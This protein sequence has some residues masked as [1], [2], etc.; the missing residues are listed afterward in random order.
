[1]GKTS[2]EWVRNPDGTQGQSVNPIRARHKVTGEV[3]WHCVMKSPGCAH[4]Y[5]EVLN[6]RFGT[7]LPYSRHS[8]DQVELF[9]D[10]APMAKLAKMKKPQRVFPF[11]M[12]DLFM[13]DVPDEMIDRAFAWMGIAQQHTFMVLTK[14]I[15]RAADY[16]QRERTGRQLEMQRKVAFGKG[17]GWEKFSDA[18][19]A[20]W[21][22][23]NVW[24]GTSCEDQKRADERIPYL[25]KARAPLR[26]LSVEPLLGPVELGRLW[27]QT[28][29]CSEMSSAFNAWVGIDWVIVGGESGPG[30]RQFDIQW[31][32]DLIAE[33]KVAGVPCF[34]KQ[35]GSQP[36]STSDADRISIDGPGSHGVYLDLHS[37]K[38][39][40]MDEW[41]RDL[42]VRE[43]PTLAGAIPCDT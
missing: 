32:R 36:I 33:C 19:V 24:L 34:M 12:T 42:R 22:L 41:P 1:M 27:W 20:M 8:S 5:S 25:L 16:F 10:D 35:A 9:F 26:F 29:G 14:R 23:P 17:L 18:A 11:D 31:A 40:D 38:G 6:G 28:N 4:C 7:K 3:G 13:D 21:P 15:E 43:F 39:N 2:I 37:K 30:S